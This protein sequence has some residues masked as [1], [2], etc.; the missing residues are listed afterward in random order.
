MGGKPIRHWGKPRFFGGLS[1]KSHSFDAQNMWLWVNTLYF[2]SSGEQPLKNGEAEQSPCS[3]VV[4]FCEHPNTHGNDR[5]CVMLCCNKLLFGLLCSCF[6]L[7]TP[8]RAFLLL[9][10]SFGFAL[11]GICLMCLC[12]WTNTWETAGLCTEW[13]WMSY[14]IENAGAKLCMT[15][16]LTYQPWLPM[17]RA[18]FLE[19]RVNFPTN[20][21]SNHLP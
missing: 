21:A 2:W 16:G 20:I 10:L 9:T 3:L 13:H 1:S 18:S 14:W 7:L 4:Q 5:R 19:S 15:L 12:K 11:F 8:P 17:F 6:R